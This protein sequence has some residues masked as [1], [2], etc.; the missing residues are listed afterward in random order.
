ME[1]K[2]QSI[3]TKLKLLKLTDEIQT[4]RITVFPMFKELEIQKYKKESN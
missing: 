3:E 2:K 1:T 4:L